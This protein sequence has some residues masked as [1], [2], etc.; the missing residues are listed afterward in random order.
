MGLALDSNVNSNNYRMADLR[1]TSDCKHE[2]KGFFT[3]PSKRI[4]IP[5]LIFSHTQVCIKL[6]VLNKHWF[7]LSSLCIQLK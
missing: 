4:Y 3:V 6:V 1:V 5:L 2:F 7:K